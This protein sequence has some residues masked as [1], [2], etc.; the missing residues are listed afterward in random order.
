[1]LSL[2]DSESDV[3]MHRKMMR[4]TGERRQTKKKRGEGNQ[5]SKKII[6]RNNGKKNGGRTKVFYSFVHRKIIKL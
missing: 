1:M 4:G 6:K 2:P 3:D 5:E